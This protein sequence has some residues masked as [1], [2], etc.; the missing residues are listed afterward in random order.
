MKVIRLSVI[1]LF[2]I[3]IKKNVIKYLYLPLNRPLNKIYCRKN[4]V[5]LL[6]LLLPQVPPLI[7]SYV[8]ALEAESALRR[9]RV[10]AELAASRAASEAAL[11]RSRIEAEV[12]TEA[13]LRRSRVEAEVAAERVATENALRRSRLAAELAASRL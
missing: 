2:I 1:E 12:A 4:V 9:S 8:A 7:Y 5:S 3:F 13:A 11:R 10:E 6:P